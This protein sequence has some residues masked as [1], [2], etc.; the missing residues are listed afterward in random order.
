MIR[1]PNA[2]FEN[3]MNPKIF[4]FPVAEMRLL[5]RAGDR[6]SRGRPLSGGLI[7][8]LALRYFPARAGVALT[9]L[10]FLSACN[11]SST[12]T[13]AAAAATPAPPPPPYAGLAS[14][15]LGQTLDAASKSAANKAEVAALASGERK[16]WRGENGA[17]G[18]V[19]P[20]VATGDCRELT[21]T[22]Y[23][24]GRPS[25]GKGTACKSGESWKLNV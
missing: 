20:G 16:T 15:P 8:S 23:I 21:H 11:S 19:A 5:C 9:V 17:Y 3:R 13:P 22:I 18:Y 14:G 25:V 1:D 10:L 6:R 12:E 4:V 7:V 2:P 24:N